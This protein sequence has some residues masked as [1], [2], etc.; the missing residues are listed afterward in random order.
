ME[1]SSDMWRA[2]CRYVQR[3]NSAV[4]LIHTMIPVVGRQ[5]K[6]T[7]ASHPSGLEIQWGRV[8]LNHDVCMHISK[9]HSHLSHITTTSFGIVGIDVGSFK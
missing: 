8:S 5:R 4:V 1:Q 9:H 3:A 6:K 7:L 2:K